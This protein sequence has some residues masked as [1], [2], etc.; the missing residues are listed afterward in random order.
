M[1]RPEIRRHVG[2]Q[3]GLLLAWVNRGEQ[4]ALASDAW[5]Q[6]FGTILDCTGCFVDE[7]ARLGA[8][9]DEHD[10]PNPLDVGLYG[11][12]VFEGWVEHA[13]DIDHTMFVGEWRRLS[14]WEMCRARFG[15]GINPEESGR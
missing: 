13:P 5:R 9:L 1:S 12:L 11:L 8:A 10:F 7:V 2:E 15:I 14:N 6:G 4:D 3:P